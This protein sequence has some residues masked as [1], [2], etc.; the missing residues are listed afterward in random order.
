MEHG[1][2][3]IDLGECP[4]RVGF[5]F[6]DAGARLGDPAGPGRPSDHELVVWLLQVVHDDDL[7]RSA[8]D[9]RLLRAVVMRGHG[10]L[11]NWASKTPSLQ[12]Y[13]N[14]QQLVP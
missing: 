8:P 13:T 11:V 10:Q 5:L 1:D 6:L 7:G 12:T 3:P 4:R 2:Q 14:G 9:N